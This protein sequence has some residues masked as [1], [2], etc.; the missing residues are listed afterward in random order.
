MRIVFVCTTN[1]WGSAMADLVARAL[2]AEWD[3]DRQL[4]QVESVGVRAQVGAA[5][6]LLAQRVLAERG[7]QA[8]EHQGRSG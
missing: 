2:L 3:P 6:P 7:L 1:V 8:G 5:V 4:V